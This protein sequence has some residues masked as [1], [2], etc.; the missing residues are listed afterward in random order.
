MMEQAEEMRK[1]SAERDALRLYIL[2]QSQ[3]EPLSRSST[4][5]A[6]SSLIPASYEVDRQAVRPLSGEPSSL[7][8][9]IK[10]CTKS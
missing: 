8:S 1:V 4:A 2:G 7:L 6:D 9:L 3:L 5:G 10:L